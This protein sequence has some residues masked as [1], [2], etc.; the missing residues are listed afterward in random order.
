[1]TQMN[2]KPKKQVVLTPEQAKIYKASQRNTNA[3]NQLSILSSFMAF[4]LPSVMS[5]YYFGDNDLMGSAK[6]NRSA[7]TVES[8]KNLAQAKRERRYERNVCNARAMGLL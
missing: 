4:M 8:L 3:M 7:A 6:A 2:R 1:M 5:N